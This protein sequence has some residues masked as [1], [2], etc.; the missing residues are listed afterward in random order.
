MVVRKVAL[1]A[2]A[3]GAMSVLPADA[4]SA[5]TLP[6]AEA[7]LD[8]TFT[9]FGRE[10]TCTIWGFSQLE[11]FNNGTTSA[12]SYGTQMVDTDPQCR[13]A[14]VSTWAG[15]NYLRSPETGTET[16][17]TI[18][19]STT[20]TGVAVV[21]SSVIDAFGD[22]IAYFN[23]DFSQVCNPQPFHTDTK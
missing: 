8:F 18:S 10:V 9:Y 23:C 17:R 11:T 7:E 14:L 13:D 12:F 15:I 20:A 2:L 22:H 3:A 21:Q 19:N 4:A 6:K 1:T 16:S 5:A